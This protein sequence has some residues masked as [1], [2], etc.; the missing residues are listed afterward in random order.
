MND[1]PTTS[2]PA[3]PKAEL[4]W[5]AAASAFGLA[6]SV[7]LGYLI[8]GQATA[9]AAAAGMGAA[10]VGGLAAWAVIAFV[11]RSGE[12]PLAAPTMGMMIRLVVTGGVAALLI[13]GLG[14]P[15]R[16]VL[17]AALCGY[18]VLMAIEA[19]LLYGFASRPRGDLSHYPSSDPPR[20]TATPP[21]TR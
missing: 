19:G 18:L 5:L 12:L 17:F 10:I 15:R 7:G 13:V 14:L 9:G 20:S 8:Q 6:V 21:G 4:G 1:T 2:K 16:P 11:S 3:S